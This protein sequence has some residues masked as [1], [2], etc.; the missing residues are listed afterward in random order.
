MEKPG[1]NY[2]FLPGRYYHSNLAEAELPADYSYPVWAKENTFTEMEMEIP[3]PEG[4]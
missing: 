4:L 2:I 3:V 1:N